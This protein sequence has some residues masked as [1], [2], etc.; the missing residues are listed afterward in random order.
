MIKFGLRKVCLPV[1]A[2]LPPYSYFDSLSARGRLHRF[3]I[4]FA[5]AQMFCSCRNQSTTPEPGTQ[6]GI[7]TWEADHNFGDWTK[8]P[9]KAVHIPRHSS[10]THAWIRLM[11]R[12]VEL[13]DIP[14][15][16]SSR[17]CRPNVFDCPRGQV[18]PWIES[19]VQRSPVPN[20]LLHC[21]SCISLHKSSPVPSRIWIHLINVNYLDIRCNSMKRE[22]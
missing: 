2:C 10:F 15:M 18:L 19:E 5:I 22:T 6:A 14:Y 8:I 17:P 20:I 1:A 16:V 4:N 3:T 7:K 21:P 11:P 9:I 12:Y 13:L